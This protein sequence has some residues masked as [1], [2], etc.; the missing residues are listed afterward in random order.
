MPA[1]TRSQTAQMQSTVPKSSDSSFNINLEL[2]DHKSGY[3]EHAHLG[4]LTEE[5]Q[6][7]IVETQE[8]I[9]EWEHDGIVYL[10][11]TE[12]FLYDIY[13]HENIGYF[14]GEKI[15]AVEENG[16]WVHQST[17]TEIIPK[18]EVDK[19]YSETDILKLKIKQLEADLKTE[20]EAVLMYKKMLS[21]KEKMVQQQENIRLHLL[22]QVENLE[23]QISSMDQ[24]NTHTSS[25]QNVLDNTLET[26]VNVLKESGAF[27][28]EPGSKHSE[29]LTNPPVEN[30][31]TLKLEVERKENV[32]RRKDA[33]A[34]RLINIIREKN[35]QIANLQNSYNG[36]T[37]YTQMLSSN[38]TAL[39]EENLRWR[40]YYSCTTAPFDTTLGTT[41]NDTN[42]TN[43]YFNSSYY[44][45]VPTSG[46]TDLNVT[47]TPAQ[48]L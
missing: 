10:K 27:E 32:I 19:D 8:P 45:N 33:K 34:T 21:N 22:T 42:Q 29:Q 6:E 48:T 14:D 3:D 31:S 30:I 20:K 26:T 18:Q 28:D 40:N 5:T 44:T 47:N 36:A 43:T 4:V 16:V 37:L 24:D 13:T 11:D 41:A 23:N 17:E 46:G 39:S 35:L 38:M 2:P 9:V 12:G 25:H 1:M 15:L 7:P